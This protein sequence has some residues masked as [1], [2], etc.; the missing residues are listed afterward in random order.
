MLPDMTVSGTQAR[1]IGE[2]AHHLVALGAPDRLILL[3]AVVD[4]ERRGA[5]CTLSELAEATGLGERTVI[6]QAV[7]LAACG[8]LELHDRTLAAN[9]TVLQQQAAELD[10]L[11]PASRLTADD[12]AL[13][14]HFQHGRLTAVPEDPATAARLARALVRLLPSGVELTEHAVN[15]ALHQVHDDHAALRRLLVDHGLVD[16]QG[17]ERYRVRVDAPGPSR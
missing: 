7:R 10:A 2:A 6:K 17:S 13:A 11:L 8:L 12:P 14:R 1:A 9:L 4:R 15:E 5:G 16:R 3:A